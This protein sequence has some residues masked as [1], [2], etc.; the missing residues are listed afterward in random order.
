M[1]TSKKNYM[2]QNLK[3]IKTCPSPAVSNQ[4][5]LKEKSGFDKHFFFKNATLSQQKSQA[6]NLTFSIQNAILF[7]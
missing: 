1:E 7:A 5:H 4:L 2:Q 6:I 3:Q